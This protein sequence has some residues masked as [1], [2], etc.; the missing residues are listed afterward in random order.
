V[1]L[2]PGDRFYQ[3]RNGFLTVDAPQ[4]QATDA[5]GRALGA[6]AGG[7]RGSLGADGELVRGALTYNVALDLAGPPATR[8][9]C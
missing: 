5:V 8:P 3:R 9:R 2:G 6:R 4:L 1:R 7:F